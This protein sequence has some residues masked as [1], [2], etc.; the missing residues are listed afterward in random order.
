MCSLRVVKDYLFRIHEK[1]PSWGPCNKFVTSSA[2][3]DVKAS[4]LGVDGVK[5]ACSLVFVSGFHDESG[6]HWLLVDWQRVAA[7]R[8]NEA[9]ESGL[10]VEEVEEV[11]HDQLIRQ[12]AESGLETHSRKKKLEGDSNHSFC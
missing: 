2:L 12:C 7:S 3:G 11:K 8:D 1:G 6:E 9:L 5:L 4:P 10:A